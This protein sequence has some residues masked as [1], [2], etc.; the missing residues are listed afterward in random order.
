MSILNA[1]G[2][3]AD[4]LRNYTALSRYARWLEDDKR[5]ETWVETV[6]RYMTF[7]RGHLSR[8]YKYEI[9]D[10]LYD[11]IRTAIREHQVMPSMRALMT[12]GPALER[13]N[14]AGY[15]C[16]YLPISDIRA[17]AEILYVLMCGTGV[18]YS[19]ERRYVTQLPP[20][21]Q[22][23][24]PEEGRKII[25]FGDS[26]E[27]WAAGY[28]M[29]L[30]QMWERG[31]YVDYDLCLIR[32][33]GARLR[34][35]GGRA[36]GPEPLRDLLEYTQA[37]LIKAQGRQLTTLEVHDLACQIASIVR[38][39]GVRRSAMISLSDLDDSDMAMAKFGR[40]WEINPNRAL[41]NNSAVIAGPIS[42]ERFLSEWRI[43]ANS[44]SG[45]RGLINRSA[46]RATASRWGRRDPDIEYGVNPCSEVI[47][48]PYGLCNLTEV[49]VRPEDDEEEIYRKVSIAAMLGTWQSTL[50]DFNFVREEW[51]RNAEEERL[52]GVS[53]TGILAHPRFIANDERTKL[54]YETARDVARTVN[55]KMAG[56]LGIRESAAITC[57]KPSGTVSTL[58][59][60]SAGIHPWHSPYYIRA[61]RADE[62]DPLA[63][64]MIDSGFPHERDI[65]NP[66]DWVF[67]FPVKAPDGAITRHDL[68]AIEHLDRWLTC[69]Q[70]Y[71]EHK[72]S[73]TISVRS[74]IVTD[75]GPFPLE[76]A[77]KLIRPT[78]SVDDRVD[79]IQY[80]ADHPAVLSGYEGEENV[81]DWLR[82]K[83]TWESEWD[84]VGEWVWE[85]LNELSGVSFLPFDD[86]TYAQAPYQDITASEYARR[87]AELP[88][89]RWADLVFFED[90]DLTTG[91]QEYACVA[92]SCDL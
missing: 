61:I 86:H 76:L 39:G 57:I 88:E 13:E 11:E 20:V 70:H 91:A 18:G 15:N 52:L 63:Q 8:N 12:A 77:Q 44:G 54:I 23:R 16:A 72:P 40:W 43:L 67:Y 69:Q 47:L 37:L 27:G 75:P 28:L 41:A 55:A 10:D 3:I 33:K 65:M 35:F 90:D 4:P 30:R 59:G 31:V 29:F 66:S 5:R 81:F 34:T 80:V 82:S 92:G 83:V 49:V 79:I 48:R 36:S 46:L 78:M 38:V 14:L 7:M 50:T 22:L 9:P 26:K 60:V 73:V 32:P 24:E 74:R 58:T 64:L 62:K 1:D 19:V 42:K 45:E 51:R 17:F 25:V 89:V 85:H 56:L 6:D 21:P 2:S 87:L 71:C 68:T 84:R 53:L